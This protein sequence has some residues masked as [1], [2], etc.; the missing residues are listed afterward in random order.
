RD[1]KEGTRTRRVAGVTSGT[2]E[3]FAGWWGAWSAA[4]RFYVAPGP[5]LRVLR[6]PLLSP[7]EDVCGLG[8][9][10]DRLSRL[11]ADCRNCDLTVKPHVPGFG[12]P[13]TRKRLV[14][15]NAF[16]RA[17]PGEMSRTTLTSRRG[18]LARAV[19]GQSRLEPVGLVRVSA[20]FAPVGV[21]Y[22]RR[23]VLPSLTRALAL[24]SGFVAAVFRRREFF[25]GYRPWILTAKALL[26]SFM[27]NYFALQRDHIFRNVEVL[28]YVF[29]V[30][31]R[32]HEKDMHYYQS[33]LEAILANSKDARIFCLIHKM[34]L[35]Q[36]E[37]RE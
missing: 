11:S 7:A 22:K 5:L 28:I 31:S 26:F 12:R 15:C 19:S 30:E 32:E 18:T 10:C 17:G 27:E 4:W 16:L 25:S 29:D 13:G 9:S 24:L 23:R 34:D 36:E 2:Q 6:N 20:Q 8:H 14:L 21:R 37:M 1:E 35:V 3:S 33:C